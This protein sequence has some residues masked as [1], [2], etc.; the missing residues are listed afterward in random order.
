MR[1]Q[2]IKRVSRAISH[3]LVEDK[4]ELGLVDVYKIRFLWLFL[5]IKL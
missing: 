3:I 1:R 5:Q 2:N 4:D